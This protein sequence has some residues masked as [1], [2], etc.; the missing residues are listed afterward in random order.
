MEEYDGG[1]LANEHEHSAEGSEAHTAS[2]C[3][4]GAHP[5]E[6]FKSADGK[7]AAWVDEYRDEACRVVYYPD[8]SA[9][10]RSVLAVFNVCVNKSGLSSALPKAISENRKPFVTQFHST[11]RNMAIAET[12]SNPPGS[13]KS[14]AEGQIPHGIY[15]WSNLKLVENGS[16][17]LQPTLCSCFYCIRVFFKLTKRHRIDME[18]SNSSGN[19][20]A[21]SDSQYRGSV[22][23]LVPRGACLGLRYL[24]LIAAIL[25]VLVA[26]GIGIYVMVDL[27]AQVSQLSCSAAQAAST[28]INGQTFA[29]P[30]APSIS[31]DRTTAFTSPFSAPS[32][33]TSAL[34]S[35]PAAAVS[36]SLLFPSAGQPNS[37]APTAFRHL[38]EAYEEDPR[39]LQ[40]EETAAAE[41]ETAP[42]RTGFVGAVPALEYF[43]SLSAAL[44]PHREDSLPSQ[45]RSASALA[46][47]ITQTM[48]DVKDNLQTL[49]ETLRNP[50]NSGMRISVGGETSDSLQ[51]SYHISPLGTAT[52]S[53]LSSWETA[54][55]LLPH[56]LLSIAEASDRL[57]VDMENNVQQTNNLPSSTELHKAKVALKD[58][59]DTAHRTV[60][61]LSKLSGPLYWGSIA[62]SALI[63]C[64]LLLAS[65]YMCCLCCCNR[66]AL[67]DR[68]RTS[69]GC[70]FLLLLASS[71]ALVASGGLLLGTA[72]VTDGCLY[73]ENC[74]KDEKDVDDLLQYFGAANRQALFSEGASVGSNSTAARLLSACFLPNQERDLVR[75]FDIGDLVESGMHVREAGENAVQNEALGAHLLSLQLQDAA[76]ELQLLENTYWLL[77]IDPMTLQEED[78]EGRLHTYREVL[79]SGVQ[80]KQRTIKAKY[81]SLGASPAAPGPQP[82][83]EV[84]PA[85]KAIGAFSLLQN[86][87]TEPAD[88][89]AALLQEFS[90]DPRDAE[91]L[92]T[93][94]QEAIRGVQSSS[95]R[96]EDGVKSSIQG[97]VVEL[98][99]LA[100]GKSEAEK[101]QLLQAVVRLAGQANAE[102]Q[103]AK[104]NGGSIDVSRAEAVR[105]KRQQ[106]RQRSTLHKLLQEKCLQT[107][108]GGPLAAGKGDRIVI[109]GMED[110]EDLV[111]PF[112]L[113]SLHSSSNSGDDSALTID[114]SF[115]A[116]SALVF[117][118]AETKGSQEEQLLFRNAVW[119]AAKKEALR[120]DT[121]KSFA[122]PRRTTQN[123]E[124]P[125][126]WTSCNFEEFQEATNQ[127]LSR[128]H[129]QLESLWD[130]LRVFFEARSAVYRVLSDDFRSVA[131]NLDCRIVHNEWQPVRELVC[132]RLR[133]TGANLALLLLVL[134]AAALLLLPC[135]CCVWRAGVENSWQQRAT[136][137]RKPSGNTTPTNT[138]WDSNSPELV[139]APNP[140]SN[141]GNNSGNA[142]AAAAVAA[143]A[144]ATAAAASG[145]AQQPQQQ[146]YQQSDRYRPVR[147][148]DWR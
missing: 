48:A 90:P 58:T 40:E 55:H 26:M 93:A 105:R 138:L 86:G 144:A 109:F 74:L 6:C 36:P 78:L 97:L 47:Q 98:M 12:T 121:A 50:A 79:C 59:L 38:E 113:S 82:D 34:L 33:F 35:T 83:D 43:E 88:E 146:R 44:D 31:P 52:A 128:M 16:S 124:R 46:F 65:F 30:S 17:Q 132:D 8:T 106:A 64:L 108:A 42:N 92:S 94:F 71:A 76:A 140:H 20:T 66:D 84:G 148:D 11:V 130:Q 25:V 115:D 70:L 29:N 4:L 37:A 139:S 19:S 51:A 22:R 117:E 13:A 18:R 75:V 107:A 5:D 137:K 143:A 141:N 114:A 57:A 54:V 27:R 129:Q 62:V 89:L 28:I 67:V 104:R 9:I 96:W 21:A 39:L 32:P 14:V 15:S 61:K 3:L 142:A 101:A 41:N 10:P 72:A 102:I 1:F 91:R 116:E 99:R 95:G 49:Q 145:L 110:L 134:G 24:V 80:D 23:K 136:L 73:M 2:T 125:L 87:D 100:A 77:L 123:N 119:W 122:C 81:L 68:K 118:V 126:H 131:S 53:L 112:L 85:L 133:P 60:G 63:G 111:A 45:L 127:L 103:A 147:S 69:C 135:F 56:S 120:A 7:Y